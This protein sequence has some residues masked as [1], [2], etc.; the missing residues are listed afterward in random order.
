MG[1]LLCRTAL[2]PFKQPGDQRAA[3]TWDATSCYV[4]RW[5]ASRTG[6]NQ[7]TICN[8][9]EQDHYEEIQPA[10]EVHHLGTIPYCHF[11][12][13]LF[14]MFH[15]TFWPHDVLCS[16]HVCTQMLTMKSLRFANLMMFVWQCGGC[17]SH[18]F[19]LVPPEAQVPLVNIL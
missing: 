9:S 17:V 11:M 15:S 4:H 19:C 6:M 16:V 13:N 2:Q 1:A 7:V 12:G 3:V 14:I 18:V 5:V 8:H 10:M